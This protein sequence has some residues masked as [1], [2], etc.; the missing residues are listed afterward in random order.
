M[1][2]FLNNLKIQQKLT[3]AFG[4]II[5]AILAMSLC[6]YLGVS[7]VQNIRRDMERVTAAQQA[8]VNAQLQMSRQDA[9][10][11]AYVMSRV[12]SAIDLVSEHR[13]SFN[14]ALDEYKRMDPTSDAQVEQAR[15]GVESWFEAVAVRGVG[16]DN[17]ATYDSSGLLAPVDKILQTLVDERGNEAEL[18]AQRQVALANMMRLVMGIGT[19]FALVMAV[20][21][22]VWLTMGVAKPLRAVASATRKLVGGN[23]EVMIP[24]L[25]RTDE[26]GLMASAVEHF[27][28][29]TVEQN[30]LKARNDLMQKEAEAAR[31]RREAEIEQG[32]RNDTIVVDALAEGLEKLA[33]GNLT[34]RITT[35]FPQSAETLKVDFN[36][37]IESLEKAVSLVNANVSVINMGAEEISAASNDLSHRT[38]QQAATLE[39]TAAALDQITATVGRTADGA[40]EAAQVVM[41][42]RDDAQRS[43]VV[44]GN[45]VE[46]MTA[47]ENSSKRIGDIIGVID[48]IAF[49]TNL[50]A[51]NA[52][53]EAARAG[54]AGRGFAVVASEVRALAQRSAAAAKEIKT[55]ISASGTQVS[56]GVNLVGQT[57]DALGRIVDRVAQIDSLVREIAASAQEQATGL[58]QVNAAVNQMDQVTQQNAAMVEESTAACHALA[59]EAADLSASVARFE[60]S[61]KLATK[62]PVY[63]AP[64]V[65]SAPAISAPKP[66]FQ[67]A[68]QPA[69]SAQ[70]AEAPAQHVVARPAKPVRPANEYVPEPAPEQMVANAKAS[71]NTGVG[72]ERPRSVT[73]TISALRAKGI[74]GAALQSQPAEDGWE[75]F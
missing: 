11:R 74:G 72:A 66:V 8:A 14:A 26:V 15:A 13:S 36:A 21:C 38:E 60:V 70:P 69:F 48:E 45:A 31:L 68:P 1:M 18:L 56:Q 71:A 19:V 34:W 24:A 23:T 46:A 39:Q 32:R 33:N 29:A 9:A 40:K 2:A 5:A 22:G 53:V 17:L 75:E 59:S 12:P 54:D 7:G 67:P 20:A 52:G 73:E 27:K 6:V 58:A 47:I 10:L 3:F 35:D 65:A 37:A 4:G 43:G 16:L 57:G 44:V 41:G 63:K 61:Q 50:L 42:A 55:L 49:Q 64:V 51:L 62:P 28:Q 25:G 30:A